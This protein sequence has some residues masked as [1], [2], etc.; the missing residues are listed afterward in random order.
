[1]LKTHGAGA[2]CSFGLL[3]PQ[4]PCLR[5]NLLGKFAMADVFLIATLYHRW[6]KASGVAPR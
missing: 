6:S 4:A 1:M 2:W 3:R 5:L